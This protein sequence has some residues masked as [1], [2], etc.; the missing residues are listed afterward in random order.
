VA[1]CER[2]PL[3]RTEDQIGE[4]GVLGLQLLAREARLLDVAEAVLG[5]EVLRF[6]EVTVRVGDLSTSR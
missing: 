2:L 3:A 1:V 6:L 5:R 4:A